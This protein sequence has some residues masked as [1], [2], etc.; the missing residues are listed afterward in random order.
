MKK[1]SLSIIIM[2]GIVHIVIA[3]AFRDNGGGRVVTADSTLQEFSFGEKAR[4]V[5]V[6]N[7]GAT[8]QIVFVSVNSD[9]NTLA[10]A[11]LA[12]N[13]LPIRGG[14]EYKFTESRFYSNIVFQARSGDGSFE[15]D[16]SV[17]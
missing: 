9:T 10:V 8:T 4:A 15:V 11:I 1:L 12:T 16:I 6:F 14:N 3:G 13:A 2:L 7:S 17:K 5:T